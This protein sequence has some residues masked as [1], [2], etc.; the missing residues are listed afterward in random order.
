MQLGTGDAVAVGD[1]EPI[2]TGVATGVE[3]KVA[4]GVAVTPVSARPGL[5]TTT[6]EAAVEAA[7][8]LTGGRAVMACAGAGVTGEG[9]RPQ[10]AAQ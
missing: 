4:A 10:V 1:G 2:F 5:D 7:G 3:A 6:G 9:Q 8:V